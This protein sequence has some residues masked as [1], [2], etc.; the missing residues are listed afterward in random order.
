MGNELGFILNPFFFKDF[1]EDSKTE[2]GEI[3]VHSS[4]GCNTP[5]LAIVRLGA[6]MPRSPFVW[7][8]PCTWAIFSFS[9]AGESQALLRAAYVVDGGFTWVS[10]SVPVHES[11]K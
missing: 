7:Q 11:G 9:R 2:M 4:N 5:G 3:F 6:G 8:R 10:V 1:L